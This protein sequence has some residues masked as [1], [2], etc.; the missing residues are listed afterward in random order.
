M[1][2]Y[3]KGSYKFDPVTGRIAIRTTF[4]DAGPGIPHTWNVASADAGGSFRSSAEVETWIDIPQD[5][6]DGLMGAYNTLS[7]GS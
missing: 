5:V 6:I 3:P 7:S 1:S 2:E 4:Q